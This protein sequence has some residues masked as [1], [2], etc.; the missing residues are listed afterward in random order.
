MKYQIK[1]SFKHNN[2]DMKKIIIETIE[3]ENGYYLTIGK[4]APWDNF[5]IR[6]NYRIFKLIQKLKNK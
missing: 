2:K 3:Y 5:H 4:K 6:I 1:N